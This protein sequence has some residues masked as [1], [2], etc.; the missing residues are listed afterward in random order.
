MSFRFILGLI[1]PHSCANILLSSLPN[2]HDCEAFQLGVW[3][4]A[5][6]PALQDRRC[7]YLWFF[8][9]VLLPA[10]GS[11]LTHIADGSST[12]YSK[13]TLCRSPNT[14]SVHPSL[15]HYSACGLQLLLPPQ[16]PS[17]LS[18]TQEDPRLCLG[19][20]S[21]CQGLETLSRQ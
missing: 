13:G 11:W 14:S 1:L 9:V 10:W 5:L 18:S 4:Q 3:G 12:E 16:S 15:V 6:L 2:A 19:S 17:S 21:R 20:P 7:C 8:S